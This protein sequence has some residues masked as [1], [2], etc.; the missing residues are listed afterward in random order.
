MNLVKEAG[1]VLATVAPTIAT[2][3]G[4]PF[5]G[6]AVNALEKALGLDAT[7]SQDAKEAQINQA[8][9]TATP[10]Q[11]LALRKAEN[12]F[13]VQLETLGIQ[14]EQLVYQ[15]V[16]SARAMEVSTRD[17][18]VAR[19]AWLNVGGFLLVAVFL[20]V[21]AVIWPEQVSKV[22]ATAWA[23]LGTV[24]GYLAK[25][26]SQTEAF[27]FGSSAG[28]QAKDATIADIAKS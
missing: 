19:L 11:I 15:D 7:Q 18:T 10:D 8:L 13:Q 28:S 2:A 4:G 3:V 6:I 26:A 12:D 14:R 17:P 24:F 5:A 23:T 22:P 27:Y 16:Q 9:S 1:H 21:A 25:S 20:I